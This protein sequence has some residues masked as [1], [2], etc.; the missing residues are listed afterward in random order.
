MNDGI[1]NSTLTDRTVM[2]GSHSKIQYLLFH[3]NIYML[4]S[5]HL[6]NSITRVYITDSVHV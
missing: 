6:Q 5:A 1:H 3:L 2:H 4:I